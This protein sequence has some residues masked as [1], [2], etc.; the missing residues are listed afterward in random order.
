[1]EGVSGF[2]DA[3]KAFVTLTTLFL[4]LPVSFVESFEACRRVRAEAFRSRGGRATP[5]AD[6]LI[7]V[8]FVAASPRMRGW[9]QVSE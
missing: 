2:R 7:R 6:V 1:M 5:E 4:V 9:R 8:R 3:V